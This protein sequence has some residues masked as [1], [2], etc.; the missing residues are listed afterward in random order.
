MASIG[1]VVPV[2]QVNTSSVYPM[3]PMRY[4]NLYT[5]ENIENNAIPFPPKPISDGQYSMFGQ[6]I[7]ID[8]AIIRS[9]ESQGLRRLYPRE[10][11]HKRELKKINASIL[12]NF[13]DIIDVLVRCPETHKR[14]EKCND[15]QLLFITVCL[16]ISL[17]NCVKLYQINS[18]NS[19]HHF[20]PFLY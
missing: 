16:F 17:I 3:P 8:D 6:T 5:D 15:I 11:D 18:Y 7:A 9:L 4:I 20:R 12:V 13:L 19:E 2:G 10:Y 1:S 14:E